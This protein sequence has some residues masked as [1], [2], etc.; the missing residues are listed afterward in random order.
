M[1]EF[2][3]GDKIAA[4]VRSG[5]NGPALRIGTIERIGRHS[6]VRGVRHLTIRDEDGKTRLVSE[7]ASVRI[8]ADEHHTMR[9]LYDYRMVYNALAAKWFDDQGKA[10]KSW[11]HHDGEPCFGGG[12]FIVC[13][14]T[15]DG[16]ATNHYKG[17]FWHLFNIPEVDL[18]PEWDGHTPAEALERLKAML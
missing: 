6:G 18:A 2:N 14:N 13:L 8:E 16:W 3:I 4:A 1:T 12:W 15:P 7:S 9:E 5:N 10:V 17:E 11:Y